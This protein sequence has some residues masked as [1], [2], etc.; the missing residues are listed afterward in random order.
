MEKK[1][2]LPCFI[3]FAIAI[4]AFV[5]YQA[6]RVVLFFQRPDAI[7]AILEFLKGLGGC[8]GMVVLVLAGFYL[9]ALLAA[10]ATR[11]RLYRRSRDFP[12]RC[13]P[14]ELERT[15]PGSI[16][17]SLPEVPG[18]ESVEPLY[19]LFSLTNLGPSLA[20]LPARH[21][22][23][24]LPT[25]DLSR[26]AQLSGG[27]PPPVILPLGFFYLYYVSYCQQGDQAV[28]FSPPNEAGYT[29]PVLPNLGDDRVKVVIVY[30][31]FMHAENLDQIIHREQPLKLK[32]VALDEQGR[33]DPAATCKLY[34]AVFQWMQSYSSQEDDPS[35]YR[36][37]PTIWP[38]Y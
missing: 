13:L 16:P 22:W 2:S 20:S 10:R 6:Y 31:A 8:L 9:Y 32:L 5:V 38:W 3:L 1:D 24:W 26:F 29:G 14:L 12:V 17:A 28:E 23:D 19:L 11:P 30:T 15:P 36:S 37:R 34:D 33:D 21:N 27:R 4:L 18:Q 25:Q 35:M 7:W